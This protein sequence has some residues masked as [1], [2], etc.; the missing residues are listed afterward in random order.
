MED[1]LFAGPVDASGDEVRRR[2]VVCS[3]GDGGDAARP[4]PL[5]PPDGVRECGFDTSVVLTERGMLP[6]VVRDLTESAGG[7]ED[8]LRGDV[9]RV[10]VDLEDMP[11]EPAR[12][13]GGTCDPEVA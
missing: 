12:L 9:G 6:D 5:E 10:V 8:N 4:E 3:E 11:G 7:E 1:L 13:T 2:K